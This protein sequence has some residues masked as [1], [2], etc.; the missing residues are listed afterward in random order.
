MA[1]TQHVDGTPKTIGATTVSA[2]GGGQA[3]IV[4]ALLIV[5][6][7]GLHLSDTAILGLALLLSLA[8][9]LIGGWLSPSKAAL[10]RQALEEATP[11]AA[12]F[13][14]Q[15]QA[16]NATQTAQIIE[17]LPVGDPVI[18][19]SYLPDTMTVTSE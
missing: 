1:I 2:T 7:F 13:A 3:G 19:G 6:L 8:G 12:D 10:V 15:V 11:S 5:E 17:A 4:I 18:V 9:S 16:A 14:A